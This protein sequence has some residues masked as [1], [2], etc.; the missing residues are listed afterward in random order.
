MAPEQVAA[1]PGTIGPSADLH[2][3][4]ALLYHLLTG[5]PPFQGSLSAETIDQVRNLDPVPPRRFNGRIPR[6]LETICLK[7]LE[8]VAK[9]RYEWAEALAG[10]LRLWLDGRA[11]DARRVS[12]MG[13]AWRLCRRNPAV[14][15]LLATLA[16]TLATGV[17]GL[18]VLLKQA[19]IERA[20]LA[21]VRRNAEACEH[22]SA[23]TADH[24]VNFL[25][26]AIRQQRSVNSDQMRE[27][28]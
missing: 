28:F 21:E 4:G 16:M 18:M 3:L 15:V 23:N 19:K 22:F 10:D 27:P 5:R 12:P 14:S 11:I 26:T 25:K 2:A 17:V 20:R 13:Q 6:D 8:K 24:L 7:C 1:L 9:R